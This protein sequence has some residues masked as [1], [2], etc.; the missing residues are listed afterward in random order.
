MSKKFI[1]IT[2]AAG[3]VSFAGAFGFALLTRPSKV[4]LSD[5]SGQPA[6][7]DTSEQALLR[8]QAGA[9]STVSEASSQMTKA[10]TEQ[11]LK[12]LIL[13]VRGKIQEY[14]NK[15]L[16]LGVH[17]RRLQ[18]TQDMLKKDI[19]SLNNLRIELASTIASLKN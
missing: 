1:I 2:A 19:E 12:N 14:N 4:S 3:L 5:E 8:R 10:M 13:D 7:D 11:Q 6:L 9:I 18:L 15:L 16:T 17:E